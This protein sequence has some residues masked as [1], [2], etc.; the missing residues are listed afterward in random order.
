MLQ[1]CSP[2]QK[3]TDCI[4]LLT[5]IMIEWLPS[6]RKS[7]RVL[8]LHILLPAPVVLKKN[9]ISAV[10]D[11]SWCM[12]KNVIKFWNYEFSFIITGKRCTRKSAQSNRYFFSVKCTSDNLQK[13]FSFTFLI[14][15][16]RQQKIWLPVQIS[17]DLRINSGCVS[18]LKVHKFFYKS[19]NFFLMVFCSKWRDSFCIFILTDHFLLQIIISNIKYIFRIN[20]FII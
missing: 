13:S 19:L 9:S 7:F 6:W 1:P 14:L 20:G 10:Y 2:K 17:L 11:F 16:T 3:Y 18:S 8:Y 5:L 12:D 4:A 15:N